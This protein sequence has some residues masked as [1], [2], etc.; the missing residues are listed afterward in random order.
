[1]NND[2]SH[3]AGA[4][5]KLRKR[6]P[7]EVRLQTALQN[8]YKDDADVTWRGRSFQVRAVATGL[9][10]SPTVDSRV[11]WTSSTVIRTMN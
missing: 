3:F 4:E 6:T 8:R 5:Q 11:Q 10:R 2:N 9:A 1:M 7:E